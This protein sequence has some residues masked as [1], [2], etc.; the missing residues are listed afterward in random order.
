MKKKVIKNITSNL[1]YQLTNIAVNFLIIP[2]ILGN[3]GSGING[4]IQTIRQILNYVS[5]VGSGISESTVLSLYKPLNDK[6]KKSISA[7]VNASGNV[8]FYAGTIFFIISVLV[9]L[10]Y[11]LITQATLD[12]LSSVILIIILCA[13]SASEF[14]V[15]GKYRAL[16]I[17]DQKIYIINLLQIFSAITSLAITYILITL[18]FNI[19]I[20]QLGVALSY[21]AR[22]PLIIIYMRF[23][24][25]YLDSHVTADL[26]AM[27]KRK[28][29]TVH[30]LAGVISF[31]SQ[32]VILSLFCGNEEASVYSVYAL[33]FTGLNMLLSTLSSA[34]IPSFGTMIANG[35]D[36]KVY[37]YFRIYEV[38]FY[39][40]SFLCYTTAYLVILP[41]IS[42]YTSNVL[43]DVVYI[44]PSVALLFVI[45]GILNCIRTPGGTIINSAGHYKETQSRAIIEMIICL[46]L[47]L[48]LVP[49]IGIEGVLIASIIA[50]FYRTVDVLFYVNSKII[51]SA[52]K[53]SIMNITPYIVIS[54]FIIFIFEVYVDININS[55][56]SFVYWALSIF[57]VGLALNVL[58]NLIFNK[59][60]L[61][62]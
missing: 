28:S 12:Y 10:I 44:R 9:A 47:Q 18:D 6:N 35:E 4:L 41:F 7:I 51:S 43:D 26:S 15:I 58:Y 17:A 59:K 50:Y 23:N 38:C 32:I 20:V 61:L 53:D 19:L 1:L 37:K 29:A 13:A 31:G 27:S 60:L 39:G 40:I 46:V 30:Q 52:V 49:F 42:L 5:L 16:L 3:F 36:K 48:I 22:I 45:M 24:Y 55:Y 33:V 54:F 56:F 25:S 57:L 8:F 34:L 14:F 2:L 62:G 21:I 11:P